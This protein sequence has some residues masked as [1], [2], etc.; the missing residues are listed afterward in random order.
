MNKSDLCKKVFRCM[1]SVSPRMNEAQRRLGL[2]VSFFVGNVTARVRHLNEREVI[3][4]SRG[5]K[6]IWELNVALSTARN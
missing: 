3:V 1:R 6:D 2:V 5:D 4:Y